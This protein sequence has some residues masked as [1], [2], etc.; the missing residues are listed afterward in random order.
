MDS[1]FWVTKGKEYVVLSQGVRP[2]YGVGVWIIADDNS[3]VG[4]DLDGFEVISQYIPSNWQPHMNAF[5]WYTLKPNRWR[6]EFD[7]NFYDGD[8][9]AV[10]VFSEEA[11]I[12]YREHGL[13]LPFG[14]RCY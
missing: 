8:P 4:A 12:I 9:E 6:G 11:T 13:D 7:E 1:S 14:V 5:G 2:K 10:Q 3:T